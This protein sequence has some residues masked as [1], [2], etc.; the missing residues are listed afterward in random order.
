MQSTFTL[1]NGQTVTRNALQAAEVQSG[2]QDLTLQLLGITLPPAGATDNQI[3]QVYAQVRID[4][5]RNG[6]PDWRITEDVGFIK[7]TLE[8]TQ[9]LL[10][11]DV[12]TGVDQNGIPYTLTAYGR[13]WRVAWTFYGP[14]AT[15]RAS[16]VH[17]S[18]LQD[19]AIGLWQALGLAIVPDY[20]LP[21]R[22][23]ELFKAEWWERADLAV[24]FNERATSQLSTQS[25]LSVP[26][27][28]TT[29]A[30]LFA[31]YGTT[32][33]GAGTYGAERVEQSTT[34]T[35]TAEG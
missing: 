6:Q 5:P 29:Q 7:A 35:E 11:R 23:P 26:T 16:I 14:N 30:S 17:E 13:T 27:S 22:M 3:D 25:V 33:Y 32:G 8:T 31:G 18:L 15:D 28:V 4:W 20:P 1:P 24:Q 34:V 9:N 12:V 19:F 10:V 2:I 21:T